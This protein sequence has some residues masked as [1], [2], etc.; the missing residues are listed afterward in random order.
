MEDRHALAEGER[1]GRYP[2]IMCVYQRAGGRKSYNHLADAEE[3]ATSGRR[4]VEETGDVV[5]NKT[6]NNKSILCIRFQIVHKAI[7]Y[8][9]LVI[10]IEFRFLSKMAN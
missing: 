4:A 10:L 2:R 5:G 3:R 7:V 9:A 6:G 1:C 8:K